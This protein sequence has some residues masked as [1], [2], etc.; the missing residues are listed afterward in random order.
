MTVVVILWG[1]VGTVDV[2]T[3][4]SLSPLQY[5]A[6]SSIAGACGTFLF[7]VLRRRASS[8]LAYRAADHPK[9]ICLSLLGFSGYLFL[10][11]TA[12]STSP[13][14][15]ASVLQATFMV[16]I[17]LLAIPL[18][19]QDSSFTKIL[20]IFT[21]FAGVALII[22]GGTFT[23]FEP[24]YL[25]G[26]L[27]AL[28]AG[29]SF[30][31]FSVMSEKTAFEPLSALFYCNVYS[32]VALVLLLSF[33]GEFTVP[34]KAVEI[35]GITYNGAVASVLGIFLWLTVQNMVEDVSLL[36]AILYLVPF[37][38]LVCF[39][40]FLHIAFP[41]CAFYGLLLIAGGMAI[42]TLR[43]RRMNPLPL[44]PAASD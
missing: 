12:Y 7:L 10:K 14:A 29:I 18:L 24:A 6:W 20:G 43:S 9:L 36:T 38:S 26:Y 37:I 15:E 13:V 16:F 35:A 42:H 32:A 8:L 30:A 11:Y 1:F 2:I 17:P 4:R 44:T 39:F 23:G 27:C 22:S 25:P 31:L 33:R 40:L 19:G 21:G 5:G 34:L 3:L 28:C 41:L